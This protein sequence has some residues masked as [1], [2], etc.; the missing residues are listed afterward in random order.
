MPLHTSVK[1]ELSIAVR[2]LH[3]KNVILYE[4]HIIRMS[5]YTNVILYESLSRM[6]I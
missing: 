6:N 5:Y 3:S 4:C 2:M 1:Y